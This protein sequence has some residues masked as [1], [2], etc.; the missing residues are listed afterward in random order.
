MGKI[1][2]RMERYLKEAA[3][4]LKEYTGVGFRKIEILRNKEGGFC[5]FFYYEKGYVSPLTKA[6]N[7]FNEKNPNLCATNYEEW[8]SKIAEI[9][10]PILATIRQ[11]LEEAKEPIQRKLEQVDIKIEDIYTGGM[12]GNMYVEI[13]CS[14]PWGGYYDWKVGERQYMEL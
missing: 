8:Y 1:F 2:D 14:T 6:I 9:R 4:V 5:L 7:D 12:D 13:E 10:K 11:E 3:E